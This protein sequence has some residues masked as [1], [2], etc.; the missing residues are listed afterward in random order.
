[1][2]QNLNW[3]RWG[4]DQKQFDRHII[5]LR[6]ARR[7]LKFCAEICQLCIDLQLSFLFEHP[8][9]ASSWQEPCLAKLVKNEQCYMARADQ[10]MFGLVDQSGDFM[11]KRSGFLTNNLEIA[12][13]LNLTCDQSHAHQHVMGRA[14]GAKMNRSRLAQKYPSRLISAVLGAY[15]ISVGLPGWHL[16]ILDANEVI[17]NEVVFQEHFVNELMDVTAEYEVHA[18]DLLDDAATETESVHWPTEEDL[19][20]AREEPKDQ[21][22]TEENSEE[23][24]E[25]SRGPRRSFPGTHPLS[26]EA[27]VRRAHEGLGHPGKDR[28]LTILKSSKASPRVLEIAKAMR[29]SVCEK[30]KLPKPSRAGA[31]PK[32]IGLNEVVGIDSIQV[33]APFSKK[34]KYCLNIVDYHSHFQLV[35]PLRDHTAMEARLG[36]RLWLKIFGPPRKLL[37][38]LGKEFQKQFEDAAEADGTELLPSSLETPEQRG[39][40]E[41]N[42]QLFK[43]MFYKTIEQTSCSTWDDWH[44]TID[45]VVS[46]KNRLL[47]R[48]GYS[49]AQRVFGYQQ[50]IPGGLMSEGGG[51][52]A[53]QSRGQ[54]GDSQVA[55]AMEIRKLAAQAFHE[56]DCQQAI[57]AAA[58]HGPRPHYAYETGQAVYFWRRG[59][60][61]ARRSANS[62]WHG[63]ARV[64]ATQLPTTV[65]LSYNHHLVKAAPEKLRP[66]SEEEFFTL[67]GW[68][69]GIS[70][71]KKQIEAGEI[72]GMIDLSTE[73]D[74]L[75][76]EAEDDYWRREGDYWVRVHVKPRQLLFHP[77]SEQLY[78]DIDLER[79]KPW[80]KNVMK[81]QDGTSQTFEDNWNFPADRPIHRQTW[82]GETWFEMLAENQSP[83]FKR[84][85]PVI[86]PTTRLTKKTR[87]ELVASSGVDGVEEDEPTPTPDGEQPIQPPPG[88]PEPTSAELPEPGHE[89]PQFTEATMSE[90]E[91]RKRDHQDIEVGSEP[92]IEGPASKR[93]RLELLEIYYNEVLQKLTPKQKK[94]KEA[95]MKDFRGRDFERLQRAIHK[96]YNNNLDSGAYRLLTATESM[97]VRTKQP[98]KIMKSRYVLTN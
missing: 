31:P 17:Q 20:M 33:R 95:T 59:T 18:N 52:L 34:T 93:S 11:R 14:K 49:P 55:K 74:D 92:G 89:E 78:P 81:L 9:S 44:Q 96:E 72:K 98:D 7:L 43:E 70:N 24:E 67:S 75:P 62:F 84:E 35:V 69:E 47:S 91:D 37:C 10:C 2:L 77:G 29:C 56:V 58:T 21:D 25:K 12:K 13:T 46:M 90:E 1:M 30:F 85:S 28:F 88:L 53:V 57:R 60:D 50:R 73:N 80:R 54:I 51:D 63:P 76:T 39:F 82:T 48:G 36:Y 41:R 68:L 61:P 32:E 45:L 94:G 71:A 26:L 83:A 64:V 65:W 42:G 8:W 5:E 4:D 40:V 27:L 97:Q 79:L 16:Y 22:N 38:D 86:E 23:P 6:K 3:P 87:F 66:A 15:A 19:R